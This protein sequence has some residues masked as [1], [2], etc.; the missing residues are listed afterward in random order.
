MIVKFLKHFCI[1]MPNLHNTSPGQAQEFNMSKVKYMRYHWDD[2]LKVHYYKM[3]G[4]GKIIYNY[5]D[6]TEFGI[7]ER[8]IEE[9]V[10]NM[11][12]DMVDTHIDDDNAWQGGANKYEDP[13]GWS[14]WQQNSW[15]QH[16]TTYDNYFSGSTGDESFILTL[17]KNTRVQQ[18]KRH[19]EESCRRD[20]FEVAQAK[21]FREV[22]EHITTN[23][24]N[25]N[26]FS[27]YATDQFNEIRQNMASNHV[28]TQDGIRDMI[29]D[30]ND[31]HCHYQQFYR[32]I[33]DFLDY[34]Y[35]GEGVA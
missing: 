10:P 16:G 11:D 17:L 4:S 18:C 29:C 20:E 22:H 5:N 7:D 14:Q 24:N 8:Q 19:E 35:G 26:S 1:G 28:T 9:Q 2:D 15:T 27:L 30:Q 31:N 32:E 12:A 34:E 3:K 33:C 25:F 6:L 21:R 23:D 13:Q